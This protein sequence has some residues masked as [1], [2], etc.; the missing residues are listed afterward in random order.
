MID[1]VVTN[2][3]LVLNGQHLLALAAEED[4]RIRDSRIR[5]EG[6]VELEYK[7][8]RPYSRWGYSICLVR[9]F[10]VRLDRTEMQDWIKSQTFRS[11]VLKTWSEGLRLG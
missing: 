8:L 4:S 6:D 11:Y 9:S 2:T 5:I 7:P 3:G 10:Q 1:N